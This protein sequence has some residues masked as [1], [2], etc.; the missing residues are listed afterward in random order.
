MLINIPHME[1]MGYSI[2]EKMVDPDSDM[3]L[4]DNSVH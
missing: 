1:H 3:G 2:G 4:L